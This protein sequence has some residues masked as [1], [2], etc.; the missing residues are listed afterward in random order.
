MTGPR[1][2][3]LA[4]AVAAPASGADLPDGAALRFSFRNVNDSSDQTLWSVAFAPD[5]RTVAVG[6]ADKHVHVFR[7]DSGALVRT[8]GRHSDNILAVTFAPDGRTL[9]SGSQFDFSLRLW[10]VGSGKELAP[11]DGPKRGI[12]W[13]AF[14]RDG[15]SLVVAAGSVNPEVGVWDV[16]TRKQQFALTGHAEPI[17]GLA[18]ASND[19]LAAGVDRRGSLHFWSLATRRELP[20]FVPAIGD[21]D[22]PKAR[23]GY[24]SV[25][26]FPDG[27]TLATG[28]SS[29]HVVLWEVATR[30][31][32]DTFRDWSD[33]VLCLAVSPDGRTVAGGN[34]HDVV[35]WDARSGFVV[36]RFAGHTGTVHALAFAPNG[37]T[38]ASIGENGEAFLWTV[39][40]PRRLP[41]AAVSAEARQA[42]WDALTDDN[43]TV[44]WPRVLLLAE[45]TG[46]V[47]P[48]LAA[49][50]NPAPTGDLR[51]IEKWIAALDSPLYV[52]RERATAGLMKA[53]EPA[54]PPVR[55]ALEAGPSAESRSRLARVLDRITGP[56]SVRESLRA[57]RAV[58]ALETIGTPEAKALLRRLAGGA[59]GAAL[60]VEA[61]ESLERLEAAP[62]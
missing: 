13:A 7:T 10:D 51:Q 3:L 54:A 41:S 35:L 21:A 14:T 44:A 23:G 58:A 46:P 15:R 30:A 36:T 17:D 62:K 26:F 39:P 22:P 45:D 4:L 8:F 60:T 2:L 12:T 43:A 61:A 5:G 1:W 56:E 37:K 9:A 40:A 33:P 6:A 59:P 20:A 55:R 11:C 31:A 18:L 28:D 49:R 16:A 52:D 42:A 50:L 25:A 34:G 38:L 47:V 29:G 27:R 57:G 53:G 24:R 19:R 48:F 32:R